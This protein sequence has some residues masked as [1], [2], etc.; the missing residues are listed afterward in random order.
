MLTV[1]NI[2]IVLGIILNLSLYAYQKRSEKED[3]NIDLDSS[4]FDTRVARNNVR[5]NKR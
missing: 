1:V 5:N 4:D 2:A 3:V